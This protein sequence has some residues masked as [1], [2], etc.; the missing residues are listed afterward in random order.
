MTLS[1]R[2]VKEESG[3]AM[4]LFA[5]VFVILC[6]ISAFAVDIGR[7]GLENGRLQTAVDAAALAGARELPN[8]TAAEN[9]AIHY[10]Q[11]NGLKASEI[12][13]TTPY[14][15]DVNLIAV[16]SNRTVEYS[17]AK[18]IGFS[19]KALSSRAV[20]EKTS[21]S[22]AAFNYTVF[23]GSSTGTLAIN[24]SSQYI[25]GSVH[26]NY[27]FSMNGSS[28]NITGN[29]EAVSSININGSSINIGGYCQGTPISI[30]G[31]SIN[32][33]SRINSAAPVVAMADFSAAI[34]TA[35]AAAGKLY[36]GDKTYN[37]SN[38][39]VDTPIY[40]DGNVTINGSSFS[41]T[42]IILATGNITFNGSNLKCSSDDAVCFY[43]KNGNITINGSSALLDGM[44]YAP[45]GA[46]NFNG[47]NQTVNGRVIG[48]T[49]A[50]NGSSI[51]IVSGSDDLNSLPGWSVKLVN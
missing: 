12:T 42:G 1:I 21:N 16:T 5:L 13:V 41:G 19:N 22:G 10:A 47:S 7:L 36:S 11:Q 37:G 25:G 2:A 33:G 32:T 6:G 44:L 28:Q 29:L 27:R 3:Q 34:Q 17:F 8:K 46:I 30:N 45:N 31:S 24:G 18:V 23:S 51:R 48:K 50:F 26:S 4:V 39:N 49:L 20:A 15:G 9:A 43:S 38:L 35:A 40:V 14:N